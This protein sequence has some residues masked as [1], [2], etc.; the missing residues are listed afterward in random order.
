M[1]SITHIFLGGA[2]AHS[3]L[4]ARKGHAALVGWRSAFLLGALAATF[5]D[6]DVFLR[7][8]N[9]I[10]DHALHR[11]FMHSFLLVPLLAAISAAPFLALKRFRP[12]WKSLLLAAF[13]ATLSHPLLDTLTSYGTQLLW[14]FSHHRFALDVI[15]VVDL[16]YTI[17]LILGLIIAWRKHNPRLSRIT[18]ALAALYL[19]F[20]F[21]QHHRAQNAQQQ[22]L[23]LR[24]H[25]HAINPRVLP[26][27]GAPLNYRS[28]YILNNR[29]YADALRIP[30]FAP[31]RLRT[32][33]SIPLAPP[34]T[35]L[36]STTLKDFQTFSWFADGFVAPDPFHPNFLADMRYTGTLN[37]FDAIWGVRLSPEVPPV[38]QL[39]PDRRAASHIWNDLTHPRGYLPLLPAPGSVP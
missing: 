20:A 27:I 24:G 8:G 1:D 31:P 35:G 15:A 4:P 36:P 19:A 9:T 16:P 38:W 13:L 37:A 17:L 2:I 29:I 23:A 30:L 18:L 14:P 34:P 39:Y 32:G 6:F 12:A 10:T 21:L 7:T 33:A 5:P 11:S 3:I 28:I 26:E 25:A 22:I